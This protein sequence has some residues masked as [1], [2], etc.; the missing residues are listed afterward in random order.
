MVPY[1]YVTHIRILSKHVE[2]LQD[3]DVNRKELE[4]QSIS[5]LNYYWTGW[6]LDTKRQSIQ[7]TGVPI[8]L[9][10]LFLFFHM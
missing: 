10:L 1:P 6:S 4:Y 7:H 9:H 3:I 8:K 2:V 5:I